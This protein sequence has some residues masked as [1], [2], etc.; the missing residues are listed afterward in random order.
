M[1][2]IKIELT[3]S[4]SQRGKVHKKEEGIYKLFQRC[5]VKHYDEYFTLKEIAKL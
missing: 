4:E 5:K 1:M 2:H 3:F